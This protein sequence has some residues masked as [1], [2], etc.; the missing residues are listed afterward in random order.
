MYCEREAPIEVPFERSEV[1]VPGLPILPHGTECHPVPDAGSRAGRITKGDTIT[2]LDRDGIQPAEMV[3]F[4]P[5]RSSDAAMLGAQGHGRPDGVIATLANGAPSG[6]KVLRA[7]EVAGFGIGQGD[8]VHTFSDGS[9]PGD[10]SHFVAECD[11]L[12]IVAAPGEAMRPEEQNPPTK[13]ILYIQRAVPELSKP[14]IGPPNPL[15]DPLNDI[16]IQP[17]NAHSY[18]VNRNRGWPVGW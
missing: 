3:F 10:M 7:L 11:G 5:D 1:L 2:L 4:A 18:E 6:R 14:D 8:V 17:G 9:R 15:A 13:I 12:L 16:N